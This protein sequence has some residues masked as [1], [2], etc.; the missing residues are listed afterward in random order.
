LGFVVTDSEYD[1][2]KTHG[3]SG[4]G[5]LIFYHWP[6]LAMAIIVKE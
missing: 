3:Q 2:D 6:R 5:F 4:R 1:F